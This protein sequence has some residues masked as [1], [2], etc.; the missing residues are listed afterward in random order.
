MGARAGYWEAEHGGVAAVSVAPH[1]EDDPAGASAV[2][3]DRV[4]LRR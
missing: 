2:L 4:R 3:R 1:A